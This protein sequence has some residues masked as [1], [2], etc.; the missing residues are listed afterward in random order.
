M[1]SH[2][3][4]FDQTGK[5]VREVELPGIGTAGGLVAKANDKETFYSFTSF[6]TPR[7]SIATTW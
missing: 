4:G 5:M 6:T 2:N 1:P 3:S 7:P